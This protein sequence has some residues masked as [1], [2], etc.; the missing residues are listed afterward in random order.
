METLQLFLDQG[1]ETLAVRS[2]TRLNAKIRDSPS[3]DDDPLG[4]TTFF[5][6]IFVRDDYVPPN[7]LNF[8][9]I[10]LRNGILQRSEQQEDVVSRIDPNRWHTSGRCRV[11]QNLVKWSTSRM[12]NLSRRQQKYEEITLDTLDL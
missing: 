1:R 8:Q 12:K 2:T 10:G 11:K 7:C 5:A 9:G 4:K 3:N 6:A